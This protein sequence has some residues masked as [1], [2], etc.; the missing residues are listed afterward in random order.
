MRRV[1]FG[2]SDLR[3]GYIVE[4][5]PIAEPGGVGYFLYR[6]DVAR[7]LAIGQLESPLDRMKDED[8]A[9]VNRPNVR[10]LRRPG[11]IPAVVDTPHE[12]PVGE[13]FG[14]ASGVA[15]SVIVSSRS[16]YVTAA[17]SDP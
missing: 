16:R 15:A 17:R 13:T 11:D 12:G 10:V 7:F 9:V 4:S 6:V 5:D 8:V 14:G 2:R 3:W 1:T